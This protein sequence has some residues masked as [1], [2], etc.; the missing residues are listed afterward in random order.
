[1]L[2]TTKNL[3]SRTL[4]SVSNFRLADHEETNC[5]IL[6]KIQ[7]LRT[8]GEAMVV[9]IAPWSQFTADV[10]RFFTTNPLLQ[11]QLI[12]AELGGRLVAV[13][14]KAPV[15][16]T[17]GSPRNGGELLKLCTLSKA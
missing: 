11:V 16:P 17:Q 4:S 5:S 9:N 8:E 7:C 1:M 14:G 13:E 6:G 15:L 10:Y 3:I 2:N 12:S